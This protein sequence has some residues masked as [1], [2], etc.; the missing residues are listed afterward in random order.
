M[1]GGVSAWILCKSQKSF[2]NGPDIFPE[3]ERE[4]KQR[5][6]C[7]MTSLSL[8]GINEKRVE[9]NLGSGHGRATAQPPALAGRDFGAA[10]ACRAR[11]SHDR[12]R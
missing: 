2:A 12:E 3:L 5:A 6:R 8:S 11:R 10:C 7:L 1:D 9:I 4:A